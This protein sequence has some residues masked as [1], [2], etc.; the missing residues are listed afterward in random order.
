MTII[1][2]AFCGHHFLVAA[3]SF[4]FSAEME[5]K[6]DRI[7]KLWPLDG[8]VVWGFY[9]PDN[10]G[11]RIREWVGT[12]S[13]PDTDWD[14]FADTVGEQMALLHGKLVERAAVARFEIDDGMV[15]NLM[16]SGYR[17]GRPA[18]LLVGADGRTALYRT[19]DE[20]VFMASRV[21]SAHARATM[22][23]LRRSQGGAFVLADAF[24]MAMD[25]AASLTAGCGLPIQMWKVTP[26]GTEQLQ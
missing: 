25:V 6:K 8:S 18:I 26:Q 22:E 16:F 3:D 2:A 20:P 13:A 9:G 14:A 1:G 23:T 5:A 12:L 10:V 21:G 19:F 15:V 11:D 24:A 17:R 4:A 7:V